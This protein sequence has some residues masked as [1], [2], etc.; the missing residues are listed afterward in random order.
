MDR[1]TGPA[2]HSVRRYGWDSQPGPSL[3]R[4]PICS[5]A[6]RRPAART[7]QR[8]GVV[9]S[10]GLADL[11]FVVG[12]TRAALPHGRLS[13]RPTVHHNHVDRS[14]GEPKR[15][16]GVGAQGVPVDHRRSPG[17]PEQPGLTGVRKRRALR[18]GRPVTLCPIDGLTCG[19]P[20]QE[21][22]CSAFP[23]SD[24][25]VLGNAVAESFFATYKKE[26]IHNRPWP[27]IN[28]LKAETFSWIEPTTIAPGGIPHSTT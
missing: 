25:G 21:E 15:G 5:N 4:A 9:G 23:G 27:T 19:A 7:S 22:P 16:P 28:Q 24:R 10:T 3:C 26:L 1:L 8:R 13:G 6:T 11:G 12:T 17:L 2:D 20:L 18:R 14:A